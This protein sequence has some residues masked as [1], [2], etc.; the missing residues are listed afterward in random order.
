VAIVSVPVTTAALAVVPVIA[1]AIARGV[2]ATPIIARPVGPSIA[3]RIIPATVAIGVVVARGVTAVVAIPV[4][5]T[6][7]LVA[8]RAMVTPVSVPIGPVVAARGL[9]P[10]IVA[11]LTA[12]SVALPRVGLDRVTMAAQ[13]RHH[14]VEG[15]LVAAP[16]RW[17][18]RFERRNL[19]P[20]RLARPLLDSPDPALDVVAARLGRGLQLNGR[21]VRFGCTAA[22]TRLQILYAPLGR[23]G[24]LDLFLDLLQPLLRL[25]GL[26]D[27]LHLPLLRFRG[28]L[29][30]LDA[31]ARSLQLLQ[32]PLGVLRLLEFAHAP[33]RVVHVPPPTVGLPMR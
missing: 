23:F 1:S 21:R 14:L 25:L 3:R 24:P 15:G 20:A 31:V 5:A 17:P 12:G 26:S 7:V 4:A 29:G 13:L 6:V 18:G 11:I 2:M 19:P 9:L 32:T 28:L 33:L 22:P 27:L 10:A 8:R 16:S 30:L